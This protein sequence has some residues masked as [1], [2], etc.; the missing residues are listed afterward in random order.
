[1]KLSRAKAKD[2]RAT[3]ILSE[4]EGSAKS[5]CGALMR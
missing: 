1:M 3:V 4:S 5:V 2:Y